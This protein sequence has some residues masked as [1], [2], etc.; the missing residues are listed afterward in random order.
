ML[1]LKTDHVANGNTRAVYAK[2]DTRARARW[3]HSL[4]TKRSTVRVECKKK[5]KRSTRVRCPWPK[6]LTYAYTPEV[7]GGVRSAVSGT[8]FTNLFTS[9]SKIEIEIHESAYSDSD[10]EVRDDRAFL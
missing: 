7:H 3:Y 4:R 8:G 9:I 10:D 6:N 5:K 1:P 2:N